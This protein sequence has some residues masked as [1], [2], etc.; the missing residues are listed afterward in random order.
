[1][2]TLFHNIYIITIYSDGVNQK[3][4][5]DNKPSVIISSDD[6]IYEAVEKPEED[7]AVELIEDD[8]GEISGDKGRTEDENTDEEDVD[9]E[10]EIEDDEESEEDENRGEDE[11]TTE[12]EE[13][14]T[15]P[16][17]RSKKLSK[18]K[19]KR[20]K[21]IKGW[22]K[23]ITIG[24]IAIIVI[25]AVINIDLIDSSNEDKDFSVKLLERKIG[26]ST[27]YKVTGTLLIKNQNGILTQ[28]TTI[29]PVK[30]I[31]INLNI[32]GDGETNF[33][34]T[35]NVNNG[36]QVSH[37]VLDTR[38]WQNIDMDG[39]A[40]TDS[41]LV[42]DIELEGDIYTHETLYQDLNT[43]NTIKSNTKNY[44]NFS[45][46]DENLKSKDVVYT[47][48]ELE[49]N[50]DF[51]FNDVYVNR[52]FQ[53]GDEGV[54]TIS[55]STITWKVGDSIEK[56]NNKKALKIRVTVDEGT[57]NRNGIE[58]FYADLWIANEYSLPLKIDINTNSKKDGNDTTLSYTAV[59]SDFKK[60]TE[61]IP[62][63]SCT[64]GLSE[65]QHFLEL[66][67]ESELE[68]L[69]DYIPPQGT[70]IFSPS[71][72]ATDAI[73]VGNRSPRFK[74]YLI[75]NENAYVVNGHYNETYS[76]DIWNLTFGDKGNT[77]G[78]YI[79]VTDSKIKNDGPISL[80]DLD[81]KNSKTEYNPLLT[82]SSGESIFSADEMIRNEMGTDFN[83]LNFGVRT[84]MESSE[85][86]IT[87][88]F[89]ETTNID[90]AY[91][92]EKDDGTFRT[93]INAESGRIMFV[94]IHEG[95]SISF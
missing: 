53:K 1:M 74:K 4:A 69:E 49:E 94:W 84:N 6:E 57:M 40:K 11:E 9:E 44:L 37:K 83:G 45:Y 3:K 27:K 60:G 51:D 43:N 59:I 58:S 95:D 36:F 79:N 13:E 18:E 91:Y 80:K 22:Q 10:D 70:K 15:K 32:K 29:G 93:A 33:V 87:S 5:E 28:E 90:Y 64:S 7:K 82:F 86:D 76:D 24:V 2:I 34:G 63:G 17:K 39:I 54:E 55:D 89:F 92:L 85:F 23:G 81:I 42:N 12:E 75:E 78:Y 8:E 61:E 21:K 88:A 20:V 14:I 25:F 67:P 50:N 41:S 56:I 62:Y 30:I 73:E 77:N 48:P 19:D 35:P 31:E 47:Y 71:F 38:I 68:K 65:T 46:L 66:H 52:T 26:D 16:D 72:N